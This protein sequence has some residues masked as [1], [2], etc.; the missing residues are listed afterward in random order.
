[1]SR[2]FENIR[3]QIEHILSDLEISF[4]AELDL[5]YKDFLGRYSEF[6][7]HMVALREIRRNLLN[8]IPQEHDDYLTQLNQSRNQAL[9]NRDLLAEIEKDAQ[10]FRT[11]RIYNQITDLQRE[12]I[13]PARQ[14]ANDLVT[15][16]GLEATYYD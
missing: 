12:N 2:D 15:L 14:L 16:G 6:K 3:K 8:E 9:S 11:Q 13:G 7:K 1:M 10:L 5:V 4:I